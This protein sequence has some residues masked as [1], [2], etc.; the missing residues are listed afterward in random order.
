[1]YEGVYKKEATGIQRQVNKK[2]SAPRMKERFRQTAPEALKHLSF[3]AKDLE[4][5]FISNALYGS[6]ENQIKRYV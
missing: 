5:L 1:M 6:E 4:T 3:D 2:I